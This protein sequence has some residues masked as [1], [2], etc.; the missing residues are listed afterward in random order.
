MYGGREPLGEDARI[1]GEE[2]QVD[3]RQLEGA[4]FAIKGE[5]VPEFR[6]LG[7]IDDGDGLAGGRL[8]EGLSWQRMLLVVDQPEAHPLLGRPGKQW[9][10]VAELLG[11]FSETYLQSNS[12]SSNISRGK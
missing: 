12:S 4:T 7:V 2:A 9:D 8:E 3:P 10:F 6:V 1:L 11:V 5:D